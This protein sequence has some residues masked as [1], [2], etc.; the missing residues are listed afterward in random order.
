[1]Q[2]TNQIEQ[3]I[4]KLSLAIWSIAV[5]ILSLLCYFPMLFDRLGFSL[6]N[7]LL[8]AKYIFVLIPLAVSLFFV[9]RAHST[10]R[11][12]FGLFRC[13]NFVTGMLI[14][15]AFAVIGI[16]LTV[17]YSLA[18]AMPDLLIGNYPDLLSAAG[19]FIY[20]F[21]MAFIEEIAWRGFLLD[22]LS[23]KGKRIRYTLFSGIIWGIWH[24]PMWSIR[25]MLGI[26]EISILL[27]WS[28]LLALVLG[29]LYYK[30]H[31]ILLCA[32]LHT[33]FNTCFLAPV[34]WNVVIISIIAAVGIEIE[35]SKI[36]Q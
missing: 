19:Q 20:L 7:M 26:W 33:I 1:M 30:C 9:I 5:L 14:S 27:L 29:I 17:A 2:N 28:L 31:N 24:I 12:F 6:T 34:S 4:N 8:N 16:C 32:F 13:E 35:R 3:D 36:K 15:M 25:N 11:W 18:A 22:Q 21:A 23:V 10:K